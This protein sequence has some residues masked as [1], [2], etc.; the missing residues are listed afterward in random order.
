MPWSLFQGRFQTTFNFLA[1]KLL[2]CKLENLFY[3]KVP[4]FFHHLAAH[5]FFFFFL[6]SLLLDLF[7]SCSFWFSS[8]LN[9]LLRIVY[10]D[11]EQPVS[12]IVLVI[13]L[14]FV[15]FQIGLV[16]Q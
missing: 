10:K 2:V 9:K 14:L 1:F 8:T 11:E 7:Y 5:T 12:A 16:L 13:A 4:L 15:Y 6:Y 3:Y